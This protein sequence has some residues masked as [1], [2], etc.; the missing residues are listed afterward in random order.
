ML[1]QKGV[2]YR[3]Q[4]QDCDSS[5]IGQT[6]RTLEHQVKEHKRAYTHA[7]SLNSAVA[8]HSLDS[9]H[10][11]D[12]DGAKVIALCDR[13]QHQRCLLESW[14]IRRLNST[15]NRDSGVLPDIYNSLIPQ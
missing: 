13:S 14:N 7:E 10:R 11:I 1:R 6:G 15:M 2:V 9:M 4:C 12:W 3:I 8:E 5:Y